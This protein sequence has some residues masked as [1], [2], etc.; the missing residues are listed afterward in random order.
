LIERF[1]VVD[2]VVH[3]VEVRALMGRHHH[4]R[5]VVA[6]RGGGAVRHDRQLRVGWKG[7]LSMDERVGEIDERHVRLR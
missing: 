1:A 4:L 5:D 7:L 6:E 3:R 2:E